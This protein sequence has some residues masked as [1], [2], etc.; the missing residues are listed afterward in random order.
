[1]TEQTETSPI[2]I[3]E[4][5]N[6]RQIWT[7]VSPCGNV[8][9]I[10]DIYMLG[11]GWQASCRLTKSAKRFAGPIADHNWLNRQLADLGYEFR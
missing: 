4:L 8:T 5:E 9:E 7:H 1:M 2:T 3:V 11:R 6:G 10:G